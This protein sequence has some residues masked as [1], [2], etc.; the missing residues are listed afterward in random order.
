MVDHLPTMDEVWGQSSVLRGEKRRDGMVSSR[1]L[2]IVTDI[3][4]MN[5]CVEEG[6]LC[7]L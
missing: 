1:V 7:L 6:Q 3:W 4:L 2:I 5:S